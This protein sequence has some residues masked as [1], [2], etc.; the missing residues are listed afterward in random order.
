MVLGVIRAHFER[1]RV[2]KQTAPR[3]KLTTV[4]IFHVLLQI[5]FQ[6]VKI[7]LRLRWIDLYAVFR[8]AVEQRVQEVFR[9]R[10]IFCNEK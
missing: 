5:S 8:D 4:S 10:E 9:S 2:E 1:M 6:V 7:N 3:D